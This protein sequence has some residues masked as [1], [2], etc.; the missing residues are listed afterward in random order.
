[1]E[2]FSK[3]LLNNYEVD[4]YG[5]HSGYAFA[6]EAYDFAFS[7]AE[8]VA[9]KIFIKDG[10]IWLK[11]AKLVLDSEDDAMI[12]TKVKPYLQNAISVNN[13]FSEESLN[14]YNNWFTE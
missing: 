12:D 7:C 8:K 13:E 4:I 10:E 5:E 14:L 11:L 9:D 3:T 2:D 6:V 1:M